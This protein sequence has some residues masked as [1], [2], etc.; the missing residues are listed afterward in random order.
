MKE[1]AIERP[2]DLPDFADPPVVEV[3]LSMQ[4]SELRRYCSIHAGLLWT[5]YRKRGFSKFEEHNPL[6]QVFETFGPQQIRPLKV[7]VLP[8]GEAPSLRTWFLKDEGNELVQIQSDRFV[9][10]W[11][12]DGDDD[13][14]PRYEKIRSEFFDEVKDLEEFFAT[15][16]IG[17]IEPNQCE[18]TY[19]NIIQIDDDIWGHPERIFKMCSELRPEVKDPNA[20]L[21]TIE[22]VRSTYRFILENKE[23]KP[24]GR[25]IATFQPGISQS[26]KRVFRLELTARGT[27]PSP[28]LQGAR[29][30]FDFGRDAIVRGFAAITT[31]EMHDQWGRKTNDGFLY[32]L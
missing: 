20:R 21:P 29:E 10:N 32:R 16:Q 9:H 18:V 2:V 5:H 3:V 15:E 12:R 4:F 19:V 7:S 28:N 22:D 11:R 31:R 23:N 25:L 26:E 8:P 17:A 27:P 14:Y 6:P 13:T 24:I 30:F 1:Q